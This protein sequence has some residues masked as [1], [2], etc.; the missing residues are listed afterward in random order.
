MGPAERFGTKSG[1]RRARC[2]TGVSTD[3]RSLDYCRGICNE[4]VFAPR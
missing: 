1:D 4:K 2:P 3:D